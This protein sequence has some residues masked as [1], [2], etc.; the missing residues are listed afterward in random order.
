MTQWREHWDIK[1]FL[2]DDADPEAVAVKLADYLEE[3]GE[4][5]TEARFGVYEPDALAS[6]VDE[7][8]GNTEQD[9]VNRTLDTL[10]DW[11]DANLV[12]LGTI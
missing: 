8:R 12:W 5:L 7:F 3:Q 2:D 1:Q 9:E 4:R 11:A 10:Y 6:I